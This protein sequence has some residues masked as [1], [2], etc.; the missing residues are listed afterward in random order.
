MTNQIKELALRLG[1]NADDWELNDREYVLAILMLLLEFEDKYSSKSY[2]YIVKNF[3][4]DVDT[5]ESKLLKTNEKYFEKMINDKKKS[6]YLEFHIP[7]N[8]FSK[9]KLDF[10]LKLTKDTVDKT[11][12]NICN[13][14]KQEVE[15]TNMVQK[16]RDDPKNDYSISSKL[17]DAV[18]RTKRTL[19]Y[20]TNLSSQKIDRTVKD[21]VYGD[22]ARYKWVCNGPNPC[23][24]CIS[25]SKK[26]PRPLDEIPF[27]HVNGYCSIEPS[28]DE[29]SK[30]FN[31]F[32]GI[33]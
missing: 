24:W 19:Q 14:L 23:S 25:Q 4:K 30:A 31:E 22:K 18:K 21:F 13:T 5:L 10:D 7:S 32:L 6:K 27:D 29:T 12:E 20:G 8:K 3:S 1:Y 15:L 16:D 28:N 9:L 17:E 11:F 26:A 33:D 2:N